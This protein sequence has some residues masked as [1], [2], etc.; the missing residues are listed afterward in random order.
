MSAEQYFDMCE[1]MGWEPREED[2][3]VDPSTLSLECQQCLIVLN[4]LPDKWEGM[5]GTW[6][7]KDY[8][9]LE[10]IMNIYEIEDRKSVFELLRAGESEMSKYYAQKRKEQDSLAK[11]QRGR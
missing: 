2:I 9:G 10:A 5:S 3:P 11:A 4:A 6:M 7:G 8:A 1:Q